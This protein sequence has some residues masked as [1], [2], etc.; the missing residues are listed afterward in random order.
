MRNIFIAQYKQKKS[1]PDCKNLKNCFEKNTC[2]QPSKL[3]ASGTAIVRTTASAVRNTKKG[4][5]N[6][7]NWVQDAAEIVQNTTALTGSIM[8]HTNC[9]PDR[10][11]TILEGKA[12]FKA[13]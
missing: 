5:Q 8:N 3:S 9:F 12:V 11:R 13:T 10:T 2:Q 6:T 4:V 7:A 1:T